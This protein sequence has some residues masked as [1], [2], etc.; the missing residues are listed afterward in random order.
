MREETEKGIDPTGLTLEHIIWLVETALTAG[1]LADRN[2]WI[3]R[4]DTLSQQTG[5]RVPSWERPW[6]DGDGVR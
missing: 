6:L 2:A 3:E 4:L 5:V 1:S